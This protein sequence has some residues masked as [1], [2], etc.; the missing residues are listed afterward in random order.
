MGRRQ[1]PSEERRAAILA[2]AEAEFTAHGY[3]GA[4]IRAIARRAGVSSALLYWFFPSKA[5]L[6]AAALLARADAQQFMVFP[7]GIF[8]QPPE[9]VLPGLAHGFITALSQPEQV[10]VIK[11]VLRES[12]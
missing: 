7:P 10:R 1:G 3:S 8:E 2:A 9:V 5:E 6:F 11:L 4:S 12:D